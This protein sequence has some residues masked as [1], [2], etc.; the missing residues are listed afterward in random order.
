MEFSFLCTLCIL[1]NLNKVT[2]NGGYSKECPSG[3]C[4]SAGVVAV[5]CEYGR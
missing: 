1:M 4:L 2:D 3:L 5:Y